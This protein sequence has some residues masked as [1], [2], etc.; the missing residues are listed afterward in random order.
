MNCISVA[1]H[2]SER[3]SMLYTYLSHSLA[4]PSC[5][6]TLDTN[7][8]LTQHF[9]VPGYMSW[10][11]LPFPRSFLCSSFSIDIVIHTF[12]SCTWT[13]NE[14][15]Q[16]GSEVSIS[17]VRYY[18]AIAEWMQRVSWTDSVAQSWE[19]HSYNLSSSGRKRWRA[20]MNGESQVMS[21]QPVPSRGGSTVHFCLVSLTLCTWRDP[22]H[23]NLRF[24]CHVALDSL[25]IIYK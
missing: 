9:V 7:R 23:T 11:I 4:D 8:D 14:F 20:S 5:C 10:K 22:N 2:V 24:C 12:I 25:G 6:C 3:K 13:C 19:L 15:S 16:N 17:V 18:Y 1:V 21:A